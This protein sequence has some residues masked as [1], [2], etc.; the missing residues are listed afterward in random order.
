[1]RFWIIHHSYHV[2][3]KWSLAHTFHWC[4]INYSVFSLVHLRFLLEFWIICLCPREGV[5]CVDIDISSSLFGVGY[6]VFS[7]LG[8][9]SILGYVILSTLS[10]ICFLLHCNDWVTTLPIICYKLLFL[11]HGWCKN[12]GT[13]RYMS[14]LLST[15]FLNFS[16]LSS[17]VEFCVCLSVVL[18]TIWLFDACD[19]LW[20]VHF[21]M[22]WNMVIFCVWTLLH[23]LSIV[24]H[25]HFGLC[26]VLSYLCFVN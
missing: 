5:S 24:T 3:E 25:F 18:Q 26:F 9:C 10:M 20:F 23:T 14:E 17:I 19:Q 8:F 13:F 6:F 1:V 12:V 7:F 11:T 2:N 21:V 4:R 15:L 22:F 16:H